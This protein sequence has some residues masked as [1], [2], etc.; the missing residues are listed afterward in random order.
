MQKHSCLLNCP[1]GSTTSQALLWSVPPHGWPAGYI[2][3]LSWLFEGHFFFS[4]LLF[5]PFAISSA[6]LT[7][8]DLYDCAPP[9]PSTFTL[10]L[11]HAP[12]SSLL[13]LVCPS[14]LATSSAFDVFSSGPSLVKAALVASTRLLTSSTS[15]TPFTPSNSSGSLP[16]LS[17][18]TVYWRVDSKT[19]STLTRG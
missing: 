17:P 1:L 8:P 5:L 18:P 14:T 15:N 16:H 3:L 10:A 19:G 13:L 9:T 7:S 12:S 2:N 6:S 11:V 4:L